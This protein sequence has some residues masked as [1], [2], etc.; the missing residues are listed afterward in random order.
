MVDKSRDVPA[1]FA[2][3]RAGDRQELL[4]MLRRGATRRDVMRWMMAAGASASF[5]GA[6]F[7]GASRAYADTPQRGGKLTFGETVHGPDDTIDPILISS[8]TDF[9]RMRMFYSSL[10]RLTD[11]LNAEPEIAEEFLPNA[12]ATEWT[13]KL[14]RGVEFHD[15]KTLT[16]DDVIYSMNRH[17][18]ADSPSRASSLVADIDRWEK[19]ND[20]EVRAVMKS[21]NADLPIVLGTFHFKIVQD[22]TTDFSA[23]VGSGPFRVAEFIPGV[24][25]RGTR[26]ENYWADGR[27]Y[28]DEIENFA[29][30]DPVARVNALLAGDVDAVQTIPPTAMDRIVSE[31]KVIVATESG[32]YVTIAMRRDMAPGNNDD[33]VMA[34]RHLM[35][36]QR[37]LR[38]TLRDQGTLGND[39]PINRVYADWS[40]DL[41]QRMLDPDRARYHFERSGIG[42][43]TIPIIAAEVAPGALEQA[44]VLQREAQ[45]IGMNIDV[46]RVST[47]GYW[48][49]VWLQAPVCIGSWN[50]RPTAN[51]MLTL[52]YQSTA[53]WNETKFV[54]E[55]FDELLVLS[56]AET[57]PD[58]RRQM[59]HDMQMLVHEESGSVIPVHRNFVDAAADYIR[60][61]PAVPLAPYG[62]V[63]GPE[64]YWIDRT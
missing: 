54:N 28:L 51:I 15:G 23:P 5:A 55:Q 56:R 1:Q 33:V 6:V 46:Q 36:R 42:S 19:V 29:I 20:Y 17:L 26:F 10:T 48:G 52:A 64:F 61:I 35:D 39:Q 25:A 27:P 7:S 18:G 57:D 14:K 21:P 22:G 47:D 34:F 43:T 62:G 44:L 24:R 59:Y 32:A 3:L 41:P 45:A 8:S 4:T 53:A 2:Q 63:E 12:D 58:R 49:S 50:M 16:A 30:N 40:P 60:G 38:A 13:F 9:H 11:N 37:L 31:G